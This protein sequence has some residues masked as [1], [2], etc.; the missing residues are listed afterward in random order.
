MRLGFVLFAIVMSQT[1]FSQLKITGR[2]VDIDSQLPIQFAYIV[3]N[4]V[5]T[6]SNEDGEFQ[7][8]IKQRNL[9]VIFSH[10]GYENISV[11]FNKE[12]DTLIQLKASSV[13]LEEI[14][15]DGSNVSSIIQNS[16]SKIIDSSFDGNFNCFYRQTTRNDKVYSELLE[17]FYTT[18]ISLK[19][20]SK[21][22]INQG[23][24]AVR[25]DFETEGY[26]VNRNFSIFTKRLPLALKDPRSYI[27]PLMPNAEDYFD[28]KLTETRKSLDTLLY[29]I[30][31]MPKEDCPYPG[32]KGTIIIDDEYNIRRF[33]GTI[34]DS[35]FNPLDERIREKVSNLIFQVD[36]HCDIKS[37]GS[38]FP[39][40]IHNQLSYD[41][42]V[43]KRK[44]RKVKSQSIFTIVSLEKGQSNFEDTTPE[45]DFKSIN[46]TPYDE[47][48]WEANEIIKRTPVE[49]ELLRQF[50]SI[51]GF[52]KTFGKK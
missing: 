21:W 7:L 45:N 31:F 44:A 3:T 6:V 32:F 40:T 27:V 25:T 50:K 28:F 23:R 10:I 19:G 26:I 5:G 1:A 11:F 48:F 13:F 43:D 2:I 51:N 52:T 12:I 38:R 9:P 46:E 8:T 15:I 37:K 29:Y 47:T 14:V 30:S 4:Q 22:K 16:F 20:I 39:S 49:R 17:V 41:Y 18:D 24:Y 35:R 36:V 42:Q 33:S 34:R